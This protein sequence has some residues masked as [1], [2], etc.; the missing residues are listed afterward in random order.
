MFL[1]LKEWTSLSTPELLKVAACR[2][3]WKRTS[4]KSSLRFPPP[5]PWPE[6]N[7]TARLSYSAN[8][9]QWKN[10]KQKRTKKGGLVSSWI[11]MSC[12]P[13]GGG[14]GGTL[15]ILTSSVG[16]WISCSPLYRDM[17]CSNVA[18]AWPSDSRV[19]HT[20]FIWNMPWWW[21]ENKDEEQ[22]A[23][24]CKQQMHS[25]KLYTYIYNLPC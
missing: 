6:L 25:H 22:R 2:K 3:D 13:Y 11:L 8:L 10:A 15:S 18:T 19:P 16:I 20:I 21:E 1:C 5:P 14:G 12:Q 4:A 7:W 9:S 23:T 24:F 17:S